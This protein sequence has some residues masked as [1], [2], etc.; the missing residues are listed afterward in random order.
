[1][2]DSEGYSRL[3]LKANPDFVEVKS[4]E[5]VGESMRRLPKTAMPQME[6]IRSFSREISNHSGYK[7]KDEFV[8]SGV[9][10]LKK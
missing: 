8:P 6:D 10:L 4:Y 9:I 7:V 1:M 3:I 5:W 2:K